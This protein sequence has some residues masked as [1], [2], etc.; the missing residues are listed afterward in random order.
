[1]VHNPTLLVKAFA[2]PMRYYQGPDV[3]KLV[4]PE[5]FAA[6]CKKPL[7][8]GGPQAQDALKRHGLHQA[9]KDRGIAYM[10]EEFG[11]KCCEDEVDRLVRVAELNGCD[12][13]VGAGGGKAIDTG[14]AVGNKMQIPVI[15]YP[16]T[17]SSDAPTSS[18]SVIYTPDG[19]FSEYRF[20][21]RAPDAV[22]VDTNIIAEAPARYL[23]CGIGDALSKKFEVEAC[24][25]SGHNNQIMK[26]C[27]GC[28]PLVGIYLADLLY[29]FLKRWG[30][31]AMASA[32][33]KM[34]TPALEATV[35]GSILISGLAFESGGLAAAHS[36]YD[37]LT[38]LERKMRP[39]QYHG[40]LVHFGTC[41]Q[42]V[43][44]DRQSDLIHEVFT[45]GH[46]IGLP[47]TFEE[48]GLKE[49][50]DEDI[51]KVAEKTTNETETI[52]KMAIEVTPQR[53]FDAMKTV[54]QIGRVLSKQIP[55]ASY[56]G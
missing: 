2:S 29:E 46:Q 50:T 53:V 8:I 19:K 27:E 40:E 56:E 38:C 35:E 7:I 34:V 11:R 37:G 9:L 44:E 41:V 39:H 36:V 18:V 49:I 30:T 24:Y 43:L 55:R 17:A 25:T 21:S 54:D 12:G 22:V 6:L 26:P 3:T 28:A 51:W 13:V 1:M 10:F 48:I 52:H 20:Y 45:L 31:E 23:A 33:H 32:K 5:I 42:L 14:K 16:T 4:A 15:S 47:E